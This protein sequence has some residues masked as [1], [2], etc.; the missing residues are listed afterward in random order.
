MKYRRFGKAGFDASVL[1][2]GAMRLP[3]KDGK[4]DEAEAIRLIRCAIDN[5]VNY[6]DTA[7]PYH[8][9][10]SE[11]VVGRALK[12]GYREKVKVATKLPCWEVK[13][14]AD[15]D[16]LLD[17]QLSRLGLPGVDLYLVHSLGAE[18]WK[19]MRDL[20]VLRWAEGAMKDG[21]FRHLGFSFHDDGAAFAPII[22][23]YDWAMCQVQYNY[24]DVDN[25]AGQKGVRYAA[26]KG[27]PV[28]V[29]EPLLGGKL[30]N[31]PPPVQAMWDAARNKR[32]SAAWALDW[33]WDQEEVTMVLSGMSS[34]AQVKEN[35][36]LAKTART[37]CLDAEEKKRVENVR[38]MYKGL[39]AIPC[40]SCR[41]CMPCPNGVDIPGNISVYNEGISFDKPDNSRG[42]YA[43]WKYAFEVQ[44]ILSQDVRALNCTQCGQCE[45]KCPQHIPIPRWMEKIHSVLGEGKPFVTSL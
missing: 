33:L 44:K 16:R 18:S 34:M 8:G 15:F 45:D 36:A 1:G 29:M 17:I 6:V 32:S 11:V 4:V 22:D 39:L 38:A 40:T 31:P 3:E 24:M 21:R 43:W 23:A 27:I 37:G 26:S 42:Q 5:G 35:V 12:D 25:Q 41:Y 9:G 7:Y 13:S 14:A 19:R 20:G 10:V 2:F 28:V 30:V